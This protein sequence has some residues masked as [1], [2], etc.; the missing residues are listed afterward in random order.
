[1]PE[2]H[3]IHRLAR[4]IRTHVGGQALRVS[5]PQGRF[6]DGARLLDG[7]TLTATDAHGKHLFLGFDDLWVHVHLGLFGRVGVTTGPAPD[8][9]GAVRMRLVGDVSSL[10]LRGPTVCEVITDQQKQHHHQRLGA[11][12]LRPDADP[13]QAFRALGRRRTE[14]GAAL[15]EQSVVAGIGNVY[16]AELLHR[17]DMS[18]H[19]QA[20]LVTEPEWTALWVD[21]VDLLR[22][23]VRSGRIVTTSPEHRARRS[24]RVR[25]SDA[26]Y[27]YRRAGLECRRCG[28]PVAAETM[29]GRTLFWC[30]R[31]QNM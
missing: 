27:V 10:D 5:S 11:D 7:R 17:A 26:H 14:V 24:G 6:A 18:P 21:A 4:T 22:A 12:P 9:R 19:R 30:P 1:V 8:P 20:R 29:A 2:G 31:C 15:L 3:T 13:E 23:G 25:Q 16:R 28:A